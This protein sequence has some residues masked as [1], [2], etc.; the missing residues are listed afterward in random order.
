VSGVVS[1]RLSVRRPDHSITNSNVQLNYSIEN[2]T[3]RINL[4][5]SLAL[6]IVSEELVGP[7]SDSHSELVLTHYVGGNPGMVYRYFPALP[8]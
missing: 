7:L 1:Y 5:P 3:L 6:C 4:C 8:D 2:D